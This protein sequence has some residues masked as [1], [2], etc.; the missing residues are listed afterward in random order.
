MN[1]DFLSSCFTNGVAQASCIPQLIVAVINAAFLFAGSTA[2][3][4]IIFAGIKYI[5]SGGDSKQI[6][7]AKN[8]LTYGI[9]G[10]VVVLLSVLVVNILSG[11]TGVTCIQYG[12]GFVGGFGNCH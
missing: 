3:A 9:L 8:A 1:F 11:I 12:S 7:G 5:M 10:L 6:D 4:V 2:A